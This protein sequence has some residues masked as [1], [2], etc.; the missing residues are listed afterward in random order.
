MY[1]SSLFD[2]FDRIFYN[3]FA[4]LPKENKPFLPY[5]IIK[6]DSTG[7]TTFELAV[8][9]YPK[10][11]LK[12]EEREG[13]IHISGKTLE[14]DASNVKYLYKG[15]TSRN[16][17]FS[18]PL[19]SNCTIKNVQLQDGILTITINRPESEVRLIEIKT[20]NNNEISHTKQLEQAA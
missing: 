16:F 17:E 11:S 13:Y 15:L 1:T 8:A 19:N 2:T 7:E 6:N 20:S 9:G 18:I 5:N 12:V 10:E 3:S 4:N 14:E